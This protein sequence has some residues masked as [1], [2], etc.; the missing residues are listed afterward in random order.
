M[1]LDLIIGLFRSVYNTLQNPQYTGK[2][3][4]T[5]CTVAN[6]AI[7][8]GLT[9]LVWRKSKIGGIFTLVATSVMVYLRGYLVPGTPELT[10][11]YLPDQ[12]LKQFEHH[13]P[14]SMAQTPDSTTSTDT[15]SNPT[16]ER[17]NPVE[18]LNAMGILDDEDAEHDASLSIEAQE[19]WQDR[20]SGLSTERVNAEELAEALGLPEKD[21]ELKKE[22]GGYLLESSEDA[23]GPWPSQGAVMAD[24]ATAD[25]FNDTQPVW[26]DI[27]S[28]ERLVLLRS[29]RVFLDEHPTTGAPICVSEDVVE[30]CCRST[31]VIAYECSETGQRLLEQPIET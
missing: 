18:V 16:E 21:W 23:A 29:M 8:A 25:W 14:V 26:H 7:S 31:N 5:P 4:C 10:K 2:N 15:A 9:M 12:V 13:E 6:M 30:S 22:G 20:V 1:G 24:I 17:I 28:S 3:R 19:D 11:R 27:P